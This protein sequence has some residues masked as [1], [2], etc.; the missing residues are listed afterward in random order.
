MVPPPTVNLSTPDPR[1]DMIE[2]FRQRDREIAEKA[3]AAARAQ[4]V[5]TI[6]LWLEEHQ[7]ASQDCIGDILREHQ[8]RLAAAIRSGAP[9]RWAAEREG[10]R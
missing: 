6:A 5:E 7:P 8:D 4:I 3:A 1:T 2:W 9:E 10:S